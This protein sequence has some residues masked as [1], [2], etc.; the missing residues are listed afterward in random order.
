MIRRRC[1]AMADRNHPACAVSSDGSQRPCDADDETAA[2]TLD[3][4]PEND[5][6]GDSFKN[7]QANGLFSVRNASGG[8][9]H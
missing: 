2:P 9:P 4:H 7:R 1:P 3:P 6:Q 8:L 5:D